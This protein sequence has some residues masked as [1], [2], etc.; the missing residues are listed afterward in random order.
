MV[1]LFAGV[2]ALLADTAA[3]QERVTLGWGRLFSND[4]LGDGRDRWR[5]GAYT[6]SRIRG[7]AWTG[8]LPGF[9]EILEFRVRSEIVAPEHL[10]VAAPGDRRYAGIL[11]FGLHTHF[12]LAGFDS[13]LG[14]ELAVTGKQTGLSEVQGLIHRSLGLADPQVDDDQIGNHVYPGLVAEIGRSLPLGEARLRPFVEARAGLETLVRAGFDLEIGRYTEGALMLRDSATGQRYR[15]LA[16]DLVPGWS[17]SV[18]GDIA[19]VFESDLLPEG[20][21]AVLSEDL[22]R[23][24]LGV[25]WQGESGASVFY[26]VTWLGKEFE[27]QHEGQAV[28]TLNLNLKF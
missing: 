27:G 9:G 3:A 28:G 15:G 6:V 20:G 21:A 5:T 14:G 16:G 26:G 12:D 1:W 17:A 4:G 18:G 13:S 10:V 23:L 19:H 2:L 11:T 25:A 24:R 7:P 22:A 8:T